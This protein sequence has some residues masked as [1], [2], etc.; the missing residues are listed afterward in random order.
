MVGLADVGHDESD[1]LAGLDADRGRARN[2]GSME[3]RIRVERAEFKRRGR[4]RT[5]V[6]VLPATYVPMPEDEAEE[7]VQLLADVII[8]AL[9]RRRTIQ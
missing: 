1:L 4:P 6:Q 7:I 3:S 5:P 2:R 8:R 9:R